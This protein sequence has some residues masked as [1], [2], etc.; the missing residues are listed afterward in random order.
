MIYISEDQENV[1]ENASY[2]PACTVGENASSHQ[3]RI[4]QKTYDYFLK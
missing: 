2:C 4:K 1:M 3:V